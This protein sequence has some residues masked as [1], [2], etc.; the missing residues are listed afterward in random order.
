MN[1]GCKIDHFKHQRTG[2]KQQQRGESR[3]L[4]TEVTAG[5]RSAVRYTV[6]VISYKLCGHGVDS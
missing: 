5:V 3:P 6:D 4:G 1:G 2:L